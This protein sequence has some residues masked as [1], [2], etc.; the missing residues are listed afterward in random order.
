MG[1]GV[2]ESYQSKPHLIDC[3]ED[4]NLL[5]G[6]DSV[7]CRRLKRVSTGIDRHYLFDRVL[8]GLADR[9]R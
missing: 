1:M 8:S 7:L 3:T 9:A 4:A 2:V 6:A 5:V